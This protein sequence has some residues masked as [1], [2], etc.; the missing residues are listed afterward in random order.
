MTLAVPAGRQGYSRAEC[1]AGSQRYSSRP[2]VGPRADRGA[3]DVTS[4]TGLGPLVSGS[5]SQMML[6]PARPKT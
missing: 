4:G 2:G 3:I 5:Q 1:C 6:Q